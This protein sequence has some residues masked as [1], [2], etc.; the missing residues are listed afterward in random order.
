MSK[1]L[2]RVIPI[3]R[4]GQYINL[5]QDMRVKRVVNQLYLDH[6]PSSI[7]LVDKSIISLRCTTFRGYEHLELDGTK[8]RKESRGFLEDGALVF[9]FEK[10]GGGKG[11]E[12]LAALLGQ[13]ALHG[14]DAAFQATSATSLRVLDSSA[15]RRSSGSVA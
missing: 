15:S 9:D 10:G 13:N 12:P 2:S 1:E 14:L 7:S 3:R 6:P 8:V 4:I 11:Q 5:R